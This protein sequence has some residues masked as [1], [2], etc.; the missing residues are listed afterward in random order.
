MNDEAAFKLLGDNPYFGENDKLGFQNLAEGFVTLLNDVGDSTPLAIG[1]QAPWGMGKSSFMHQLQR[2]LDKNPQRFKTVMFNAWTFDGEDILEGLVKTVLNQIDPGVLRRTLRNKKFVRTLKVLSRIAAGWFGISRL[3]DSLWD[4]VNI[5]PRAR[6]Q[7]REL[8]VDTMSEWVKKTPHRDYER[9]IVVFIDDLDRCSPESVF[10][11]FEAIKLYLDAKGFVFVLGIDSEIISEAILEQKKYSNRIT[12]EQYV[13]KVIQISFH[14]PAAKPEQIHELFHDLAQTSGTSGLFNEDNADLVIERCNSNPRRIKRFINVFVLEHILNPDSRQ[15]EPQLLIKIIL[16]GMYY[17][18]F[19][20][21][22]DPDREPD[23]ITEF[24]DYQSAK[25]GLEGRPVAGDEQDNRY[26]V[27]FQRYGLYNPSTYESGDKAAT[28]L[29]GRVP[30]EFVSLAS[31]DT[32][33]KL[34]ESIKPDDRNVVSHHI[35][36]VGEAV[37]RQTEEGRRSED[38]SPSFSLKT[39]R[40]LWVDDHPEGNA[41]FT[42]KL[43]SAGAHVVQVKTTDDAIASLRREPNRF[44]ILVSDVKRDG[45]SMAGFEDLSR[46]R[47]EGEFDA[48]VLFYPKRVRRQ[49]RDEAK[50]LNAL[51]TNNPAEFQQHLIS[52]AMDITDALLSKSGYQGKLHSM[53]KIEQEAEILLNEMNRE[54]VLNELKSR[55]VRPLMAEAC[56][57]KAQ[58]NLKQRVN[59]GLE[60]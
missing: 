26:R 8:L 24:L 2:L 20:R 6:N 4:A 56:I 33:I 48:P 42:K 18:G 60:T 13:E 17:R 47:E 9:T 54:E 36:R 45:R 27:L 35:K 28:A 55:G 57:E 58:R 43:Q 53:P 23:L 10:K 52:L 12:S 49:D 34:V 39:I 21:L 37:A 3:V 50:K 30:E 59:T 22:F 1:I 41:E 44:N 11:V 38:L 29:N 46:I 15:I 19:C 32:F 7:L 25:R 16:L 51:I 31:N 5:D 40:M 14:I